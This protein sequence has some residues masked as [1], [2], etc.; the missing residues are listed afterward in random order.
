[1]KILKPI[2]QESV[3]HLFP[4]PDDLR[5]VVELALMVLVSATT[6]ST[7]TVKPATPVQYVSTYVDDID[8]AN[9]TIKSLQR[10]GFVN[11][12]HSGFSF[13]RDNFYRY[14][15]ITGEKY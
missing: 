3:A 13:G 7:M 2:T 11:I 10:R 5:E 15:L 12:Q 8:K 6:V 1:M 9:E 4:H 14:I